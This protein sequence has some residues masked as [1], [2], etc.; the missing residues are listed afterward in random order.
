MA[1]TLDNLKEM[2]IPV[3][4]SIEMTIHISDTTY[5]QHAYFKGISGPKSKPLLDY[6][7]RKEVN[8]KPNSNFNEGIAWLPLEHI[9]GITVHPG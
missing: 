8:A 3:G 9:Q 1:I 6:F 4:A 7:S 5:T 2:N